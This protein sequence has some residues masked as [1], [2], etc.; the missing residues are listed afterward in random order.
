MDVA[1]VNCSCQE[2]QGLLLHTQISGLILQLVHTEGNN[3][4]QLGN[5][6][7]Q[8]TGRDLLT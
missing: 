5:Y 4:L 2:F 3:T 7:V 8:F 6:Y 1:F